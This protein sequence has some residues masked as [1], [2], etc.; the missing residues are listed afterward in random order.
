M[1]AVNS[2]GSWN[3]DYV[4]LPIQ[5]NSFVIQGF[6][7][8]N[9]PSTEEAVQFCLAVS[10][11]RFYGSDEPLVVSIASRQ[12][13]YENLKPL[14]STWQRRL[15]RAERYMAKGFSMGRGVPFI[16]RDGGMAPIMS[17]KEFDLIMSKEE[18]DLATMSCKE[19]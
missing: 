5:N 19:E 2:L 1:E 7:C 6:A 16:R 9:F 12:G 17:K 4:H 8:I 11:L 3:Y 10:G 14:G 18:L 15:M 13:I